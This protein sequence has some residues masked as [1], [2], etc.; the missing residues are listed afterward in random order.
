MQKE[1]REE[2]VTFETAKLAK[3]KGLC[4]YFENNNP[5]KYVPAF[6]SEDYINFDEVEFQQ[7]DCTID[8]RY[9]RPTQSLLQR[10]LR[11]VHNILVIV[12]PMIPE[13]ESDLADKWEA[14]VY[15]N[16]IG[17]KGNYTKTVV[18]KTYEEALEIGLQKALK[19]IGVK[20]P[21]S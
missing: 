17:H 14:V 1:I 19:M 5:T 4:H 21:I 2:L 9:F 13:Y 20:K 15:L 12:K 3:E 11:E 18:C 8:D 6:Y 10:W 7:E 16:K